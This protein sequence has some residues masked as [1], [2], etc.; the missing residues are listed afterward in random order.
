MTVKQT[1][2]LI[3]GSGPVGLLTGTISRKALT[4]SLLPR[5]FRYQ[6]CPHYRALSEVDAS[7]V[8][9]GNYLLASLDR[10]VGSIGAV[11]HVDANCIR[12]STKC[13]VR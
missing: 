4:I 6:E 13:D 10:V 11:H 3:V 2:V 12:L 7:C 5:S 8:Q 1:D 9:E